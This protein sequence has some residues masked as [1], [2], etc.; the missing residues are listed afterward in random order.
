MGGVAT[1]GRQPPPGPAVSL[2][3]FIKNNKIQSLIIFY[4]KIQKSDYFYQPSGEA[5]ASWHNTIMLRG[6]P[7]NSSVQYCL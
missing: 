5:Q 2:V 3:I 6:S 1:E 4:K 7:L